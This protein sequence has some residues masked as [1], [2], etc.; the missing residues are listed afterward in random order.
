MEWKECKEL[1]KKDYAQLVGNSSVSNH[2]VFIGGIKKLFTN[3]SFKVT[4]WFRI[5]SLLQQK[6]LFC[7]KPIYWIVKL[8][9][10][11]YQYKTGAQLYLGTKV[12][13]GLMFPHYGC[14]IIHYSAELGEYVQIYQDVTIGSMRGKNVIPKIGSKVVLFAGAKVIGGVTIGDNCVIGAG[15]V[16]TKDVPSGCVAAGVPAKIVSQR[17]E[18]I[19][20]QYICQLEPSS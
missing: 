10:R 12:G 1:I 3:A 4:F 11:H 9:Y 17:G 8:I 13:G 14:Q 16:V 18:E 20:N 5:G 2:Q 19:C 6:K 15:A 7:Y